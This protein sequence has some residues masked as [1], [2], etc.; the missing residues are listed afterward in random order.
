MDHFQTISGNF[1]DFTEIY[2]LDVLNHVVKFDDLNHKSEVD[3]SIFFK[4]GLRF[5]KENTQIVNLIRDFDRRLNMAVNKLP[6]ISTTYNEVLKLKKEGYFVLW[7]GVSTDKRSLENQ[8]ELL[9]SL[10]VELKKYHNICIVID[11]WTVADSRRPLNPKLIES[12]INVL[13]E[14]QSIVLDTEFISLI[15]VESAQK[16]AIAK[17]IDFHISSAGTGSLWPSRIAQ[18]VGLMHISHAF[19]DVSMKGHLHSINSTYMPSTLIEDINNTDVRMDYVSYKVNISKTIDFFKASYPI[20]FTSHFDYK[21]LNVRKMV[22][23]KRIDIT[24][25]LYRCINIKPK[26]W[27]DT[28]LISNINEPYILKI[29]GFITFHSKSTKNNFSKFYMDFGEGLSEKDKII[30]DIS[31]NTGKFEVSIDSRRPLKN[32]RFDVINAELDFTFQGLFYKIE[33]IDN[34]KE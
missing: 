4:V 16:I 3:G 13:K 22:N 1:I 11:G 18:K 27:F 2:E 14:I 20:L 8:I 6:Y 17:L 7:F 32:L 26:I 5:N 24:I 9:N 10:V 23:I 29:I 19:R 30:I 33:T 15:G 12:D 28:N 31:K 25:N 34:R 21:P